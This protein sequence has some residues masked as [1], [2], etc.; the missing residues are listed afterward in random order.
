METDAVV[1]GAGAA[2]LAAAQ[3]LAS[4]SLDVV[5]VEA[6]DRV[7]GRVW[8]RPLPHSTAPAELGAEFIHGPA[9]Q[10]M[11]LLH[12]IGIRVI[13][14]DGESWTCSQSGE[15]RR[16]DRDIIEI[17]R[18][19]DAARTLKRDESTD[20]F[21]RRLERDDQTREA[22]T[23]ARTFV[24]GFEAA[25]PAIAS[26]RAIADELHSGVDLS[27]ARPLGGYAP[28]F[29]ALKNSCIA[30]GVRL[31]LSTTV[32]R[33]SWQPGSAMVRTRD[34]AGEI[35][36]TR[37][38]AVIVT[39]PVGVLRHRGGASDV[40]FEPELPPEKRDALEMIE[41][42]H[43]VK[44]VLHF[45]SRFWERLRNGAY[46]NAAFFRCEGQAFAV[47]WMP[48]DSDGFCIAWAGGP[49]AVALVGATPA[50]LIELALNGFGALFAAPELAREQFVGGE[51]HDWSADPFSRGAYS[52]IKV[53]GLSARAALA[54]PV[55]KTLF[56]AGEA[57]AT[58]GQGGTVN[59]ALVTG[60]RAAREAATALGVQ[61][62]TRLGGA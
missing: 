33:V 49:K 48:L 6:R 58:D 45:R 18:I 20:E 15:L 46:R 9:R 11:A 13:P 26:A 22:A 57:T 44:V 28:M 4:Q 35:S 53:G 27:A 43:V 61:N 37:A 40:S 24:E 25:D 23:E 31:C 38:K 42:G 51:M 21:L 47:F 17:Q 62:E 39:L 5:L 7:G 29:E 32:Q 56:F 1:I 52:Y 14:T 34:A 50:E 10:T 55:E 41:M 30:Q 54:S 12:S 8:T 3:R 19:F 16:D 2:G 36:E 59:G 60:E